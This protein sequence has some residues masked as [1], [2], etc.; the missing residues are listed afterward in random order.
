MAGRIKGYNGKSPLEL[1]RVNTK[2]MNWIRFSQ[3]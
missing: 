2:G 3:E 1:A